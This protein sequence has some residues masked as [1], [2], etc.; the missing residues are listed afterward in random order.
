MILRDENKQTKKPQTRQSKLNVIKHS[1][2]RYL[3]PN[4]E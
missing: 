1:R 3:I 4:T 2:E